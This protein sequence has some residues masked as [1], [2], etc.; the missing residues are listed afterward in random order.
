MF[1]ESV[2]VFDAFASVCWIRGVPKDNGDDDDALMNGVKESNDE[3]HTE[4]YEFLLC[5]SDL[6][7]RVVMNMS[8]VGF[9]SFGTWTCG[10]CVELNSFFK[11]D[12]F[13]VQ[14]VS[15]QV[16]IEIEE[17]DE[18]DFERSILFELVV[19]VKSDCEEGVVF[20]K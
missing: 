5:V 19:G 10:L 16:F 20:S 1:V 11:T 9:K 6:I 12:N 18:S 15:S 17:I 13:N 3:R 14:S 7:D 4:W 2:E 8:E